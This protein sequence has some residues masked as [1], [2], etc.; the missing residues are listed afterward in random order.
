LLAEADDIGPV[1]P[2][3]IET[4][5]T[6]ELTSG[7]CVPWAGVGKLADQLRRHTLGLGGLLVAVV[8]VDPGKDQSR[9]LEA[10][11]V[12][13]SDDVE[14]VPR[15]VLAYDEVPLHP[16]GLLRCRHPDTLARGE[17]DVGDFERDL[18]NEL[19]DPGLDPAELSEDDLAWGLGLTQEQ[20]PSLRPWVTWG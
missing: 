3:G 20:L 7:P 1:R 12:S 13:E 16:Q 6:V 8:T 14:V 18:A 17:L 4:L 9:V 2:T 5:V 19:A 11:A 15:L 10:I